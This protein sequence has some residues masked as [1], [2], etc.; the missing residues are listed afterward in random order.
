M[1]PEIYSLGVELL[2]LLIMVL[3]ANKL[4][5]I[6]VHARQEKFHIE[7]FL[8]AF[9]QYH[10]ISTFGKEHKARDGGEKKQVSSSDL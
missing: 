6:R 10:P 1:R 4:C 7:A 8:E 9:Q 3:L 5:K 2:S